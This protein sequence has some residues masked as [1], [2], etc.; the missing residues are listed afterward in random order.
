MVIWFASPYTQWYTSVYFILQPLDSSKKLNIDQKW[1]PE[2]HQTSQI[3]RFAKMNYFCKNRYLR[4]L[5]E[6][7]IRL[8]QL[9]GKI[10]E[11]IIV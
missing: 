11:I 3:K 7:W 6:F 8:C 9:Q 1:Y 2:P 10:H 5:S 4:Y